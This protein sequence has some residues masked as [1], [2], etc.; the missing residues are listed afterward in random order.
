MFKQRLVTVIATQITSILISAAVIIGDL[1]MNNTLE[2][3]EAYGG[4]LTVFMII[5]GLTAHFRAARQP[6]PLGLIALI[7]V[8][9]PAFA[10]ASGPLQ[11]VAGYHIL[12]LGFHGLI[13]RAQYRLEKQDP[14]LPDPTQDRDDDGPKP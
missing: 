5:V 4:T 14:T 1:D 9:A 8:F 12:A 3:A 2:D 7:G 13:L 11:N 10:Y 6:L